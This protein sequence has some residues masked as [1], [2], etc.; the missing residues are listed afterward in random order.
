MVATT[1]SNT[2]TLLELFKATHEHSYEHSY[3][4]SLPRTSFLRRRRNRTSPAS[5]S[6]SA[7]Q[8]AINSEDIK[9]AKKKRTTRKKRTT[10][11][12]PKKVPASSTVTA[13]VTATSTNINK[14]D[15]TTSKELLVNYPSDDVS[16][17]SSMG[18]A[19]LSRAVAKASAER[20]ASTRNRLNQ[21]LYPRSS[22]ASTSASP[23]NT[24]RGETRNAHSTAE[25]KS[26]SQLTRVID[27][28]LYKNGPRGTTRGDYPKIDGLLVQNARDNM[29]SLLGF[30]QVKGDWKIHSSTSTFNV[31]IVF[32]KKLVRDQ[33]TVEYASR[34]RTLARLFK[35]EPEFHPSLVCFCGGIAEG[36]H[37]ANSDAGYIFFRHMC[38]AQGIDL[39]GVSICIDNKSESDDE[40][41]KYVTQELKKKYAPQW[42]EESPETTS[43]L[44]KA[45][46]V[47]FTLVSTEYH[48]CNINDVHHRSPEKSLLMGMET[49]GEAFQEQR[50]MYGSNNSF[51]SGSSSSS[52]RARMLRYD[53]AMEE[54]EDEP[55]RGLVKT[56]W[57]F[58]YATYPYI[59]AKNDAV[60]FLGKCYLLGEEL[61]PLLVN[62]KG[63]VDQKEFFQRDNYLMLASIRRS[64]VEEIEALHKPSHSRKKTLNNELRR[65]KDLYGNERN[66]ISI[67]E[68]ALLS[69]GRCVD[70]VKP[71]GLH[72]GSVSKEDWKK[73]LK[74]LEHSMS[75]IRSFCDPDRPL[76][77]SEWGKLVDDDSDSMR[78][79]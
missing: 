29:I 48:L 5:A 45:I 25:P 40:A 44:Q 78:N 62:M 34:I 14:T 17:P 51:G 12:K 15:N 6:T 39:E 71:A 67:L 70:L 66:V 2:L 65:I 23:T 22:S 13:T 74:A 43:L 68:G 16:L 27:S 33:V 60:V 73:A 37:V 61:M 19:R 54:G 26:L 64:L 53:G 21:K 77:P 36:S 38:E 55:I 32:G 28:Q 4:H 57:S 52:N 69:L 56:S 49:M 10:I 79:Y 42:L 59:Y 8:Q 46:N 47:H 1:T 9:A 3:D 20:E 24:G 58:Q 76:L 50:P 41:V 7:L 72:V 35:D 30:N 31:A 11:A 18:M 63:V 75:E